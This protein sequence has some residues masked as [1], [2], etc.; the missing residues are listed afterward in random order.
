MALSPAELEI[1]KRDIVEA[2]D[3]NG[4][5][6]GTMKTSLRRGYKDI[7]ADF[8]DKGN[9]IKPFLLDEGQKFYFE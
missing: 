9:N 6:R 8:T 3:Q 1:I 7:W 4:C 2:C 5:N